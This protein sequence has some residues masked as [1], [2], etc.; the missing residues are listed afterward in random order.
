MYFWWRFSCMETPFLGDWLA[1]KVIQKQCCAS[2]RALSIFR[3]VHPSRSSIRKVSDWP[4]FILQHVSESKHTTIKNRLQKRGE[5]GAL[6]QMVWSPQ[7][8]NSWSQSWITW[9]D[10]RNWDSLNPQKSRG[11][12]LIFTAF[13]CSLNTLSV[14]VLLWFGIRSR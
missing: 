14:L 5:Q 4:E 3:F 11:S 6:Q 13:L 9:R 2:F 1:F 8:S 7:I 10:R 12:S